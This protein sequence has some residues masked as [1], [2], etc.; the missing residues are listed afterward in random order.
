MWRDYGDTH[1]VAERRQHVRQT[2]AE[3]VEQSERGRTETDRENMDQ[4]QVWE[5]FTQ[6]KMQTV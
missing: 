5:H 6:I 4:K 3:R 1:K 2:A